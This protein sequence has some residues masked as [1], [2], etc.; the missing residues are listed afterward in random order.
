MAEW[1]ISP[2]SKEKWQGYEVLFHYFT[3]HY[4]DTVICNTSVGFSADFI[5][6]P[7]DKPTEKRF[8][9]KL[10][11]P[12]WENSKAWGIVQNG[13]LLA[14]IEIWP[15]LWNNRLRVTELWVDEEYRR[16][17]IGRS[18]MDIAKAQAKRKKRRA[19]VLE[20]QSCNENAIA[21]YRAQGFTLIGFDACCYGN[22]DIDKREVRLEMGLLLDSG[23]GTVPS[24]F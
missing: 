21:F 14:V 13:R 16:Q 17:G 6:K 19:I 22:H 1:T 3:S 23:T 7:F 18:L 2:L 10:F 4:Y 8:T 5:K 11:Q 9:D 24:E 12:Y 15:E 20:T